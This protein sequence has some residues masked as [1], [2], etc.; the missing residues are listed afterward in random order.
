[1]APALTPRLASQAG[2]AMLRKPCGIPCAKY[3]DDDEK[4]RT[5]VLSARTRVAAMTILFLFGDS[6]SIPQAATARGAGFGM[7]AKISPVEWREAQCMRGG[8]PTS[9]RLSA[10]KLMQDASK[11]AAHGMKSAEQSA[12]V[13]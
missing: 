2:M 12:V 3:I 4:K 11:S 8:A 1:M 6:A 7:H 9:H 13:H 5:R 10:G